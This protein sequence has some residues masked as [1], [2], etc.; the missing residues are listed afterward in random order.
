LAGYNWGEN[1]AQLKTA[2]RTG[3]PLKGQPDETRN[4]VA[5]ILSRAG[6]ADDTQSSLP[7]SRTLPAAT[8]NALIFTIAAIA[9]LALSGSDKRRG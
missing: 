2:L 1:R 3:Q 7:P 6:K 4:Y 5:R 8:R 9:L